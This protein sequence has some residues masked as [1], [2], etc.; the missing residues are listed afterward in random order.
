MIEA[1]PSDAVHCAIADVT[2]GLRPDSVL[3]DT[4]QV[5]VT[6]MNEATQRTQAVQAKLRALIT[7]S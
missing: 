6:A 7:G 4:L 5:R 1:T 3:D 2:A